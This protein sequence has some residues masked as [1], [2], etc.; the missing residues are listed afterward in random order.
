MAQCDQVQ[1]RLPE[2]VAGRLD[3][4]AATRVR[5]HLDGCAECRSHL[6]V[7]H[8][9]AATAP[10][11]VPADLESR[12]VAALRVERIEGPRVRPLR[13]RPR[14]RLLWAPA[15][16]AGL[17][18]LVAAPFLL[19]RVGPGAIDDDAQIAALLTDA[20]PSPWLSEEGTVAGTFLLE[21]LSDAALEQLLQEMQ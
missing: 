20:L 11:P 19:D 3:R 7:I 6:E 4:A 14:R 18:L 15:L 12:I 9:L 13:A 17:A 21:D 16:A 5:T 2:L 1:D 8:L 10:R